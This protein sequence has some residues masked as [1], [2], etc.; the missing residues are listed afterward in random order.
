MYCCAVALD[1]VQLGTL[2]A[3]DSLHLHWE[4]DKVLYM[5]LFVY[6][7]VYNIYKY[8]TC[9]QHYAVSILKNKI[10]QTK[11]NRTEPNQNWNEKLLSKRKFVVF[12]L[13][14]NIFPQLN[15]NFVF[16]IRFS[17]FIIISFFV[18]QAKDFLLRHTHPPSLSLFPFSI[19]ML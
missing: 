17:H 7:Y 6:F 2:A 18:L 3:L 15:F 19:L 1:Y 4:Y 8:W 16:F 9:M 10:K 11:P 12:E 13:L 5:R 14:F